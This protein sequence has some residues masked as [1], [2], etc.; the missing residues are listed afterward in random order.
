MMWRSASGVFIFAAAPGSV[1]RVN[2]IEV[3]H[4]QATPISVK[5]RTGCA[6]QNRAVCLPD[7]AARGRV[8]EKPRK[9]NLHIRQFDKNGVRR[10]PRAA[11]ELDHLFGLLY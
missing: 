11:E 2:E 10:A 9:Q 3:Q 4:Q 6:S 8:M 5:G 7:E 1:L